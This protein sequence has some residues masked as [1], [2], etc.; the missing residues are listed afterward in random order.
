[1]RLHPGLLSCEGVLH[2]PEELGTANS[3]RRAS[4]TLLERQ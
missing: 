3:K 4:R 2:P 1:V